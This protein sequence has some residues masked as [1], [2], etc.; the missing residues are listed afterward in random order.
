MSTPQT[1]TLGPLRFSQLLRFGLG[2]G[3]GCAGAWLA[4]EQI[5]SQALLLAANTTAT[6]QALAARGRLPWAVVG[7]YDFGDPLVNVRM[8][9]TAHESEVRQTMPPPP[10]SSG[11]CTNSSA[12]FAALALAGELAKGLLIPGLE[13]GM[14]LWTQGRSRRRVRAEPME[15]ETLLD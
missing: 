8:R 13:L 14:T 3:L 6:E 7:R 9:W 4:G 1:P 12:S 11:S 15:L 2:F 10:G 5:L